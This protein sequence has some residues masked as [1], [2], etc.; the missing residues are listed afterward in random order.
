MSQIISWLLTY[1]KFQEKIITYLL[2]LLT[3]KNIAPKKDNP[4]SKCYQH[5]Q[6][7]SLPIFETFKKLDYKKLIEQYYNK[8]GKE[9]KPIKRHQNS[10]IKIPE[11]LFCP[12]CHAPHYFLYDNNGGRGQYLCKV[13][14]FTFEANKNYSKSVSFKC[15]HCNKA[16]E[17]IKTR[18]NFNIYKCKNDYCSFYQYNLAKM[19]KDEKKLFKTKPFNFK[20]RYI[21]R[22]FNYDFTPL[23]K[24]SP[25]VPKVDLSRIYS[26]PHTLGLVLTYYANYG[27]SARKVEGIMMD[28][29]NI[30]ISHQTVLNYV[31]AVS[32]FLKPYI[33][34]YPYKLSNSFCGDETYLKI[35]GKWQYLFFFFDAVKKIILSYRISPDRDA[36]SAIK[37]L[38]DTLKKIK[39]IDE[40][41]T[42]VV[43]GNPI[44]LLAQQFFA[45]RGIP[46]D[47]KQVI[48][49]TNLDPVSKEYRSLK[50]IVERLNRTFKREYKNKYGFNSSAGSEAFTILF[51]A[52]FNFLRPHSA[53]EDK[54]VP[55]IIPELKS[56]SNMPGKW[57]ALIS[58]A[59]EYIESM[60]AS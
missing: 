13:C 15:P 18:K 21:Y 44:Y 16:L 24:Q 52:Y 59:Q 47:I 54:R 58:L 28:I 55:V 41:L 36:L 25:V 32:K 35:K 29:H 26:S 4:V 27:I 7:D 49:L 20:V 39:N 60:Q 31:D 3:C 6:I 42:F 8:H 12:R 17:K 40:G 22:E 51:V 1:I 38:D 43:D 14:N 45:Q 50:Q 48:G 57:I 30:E 34:N 56:I 10:N 53:L 46:F 11:T 9:L 19:T 33:D 5:L 23:S 2:V 37:A